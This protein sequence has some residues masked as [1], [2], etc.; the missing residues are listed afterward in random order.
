VAVD[1]VAQVWLDEWTLQLTSDTVAAEPNK[2][3]LE[4]DGPD[5]G[6]ELKWHKQYEPWGPIVSLTGWPTTF[7][8]G[9]ILLWHGSVASIPTGFHL[10]DGTEDTPDL[11]NNFIVG[12]GSTYNPDDTG[13]TTTHTHAATQAA[14]THTPGSVGAGWRVD[15]QQFKPNTATPVITVPSVNHLPPYYALCYIMKL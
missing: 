5:P 10:C 14:H 6:L 1:V 4:Y 9:M 12:A 11:R 7:K 2:V 8:V 15:G 13:G 3:T